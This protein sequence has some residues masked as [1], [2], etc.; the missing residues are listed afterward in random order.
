[1]SQIIVTGTPRF[2]DVKFLVDMLPES[3]RQAL[4]NYLLAQDDGNWEKEFNELLSRFRGH[5]RSEEEIE[6]DVKEAIKEVRNA[7]KNSSI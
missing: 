4:K 2:E 7:R 6:Q 1:M 5:S 3:D